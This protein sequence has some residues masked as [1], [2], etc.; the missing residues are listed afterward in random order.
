MPPPPPVVDS[1]TARS[2]DGA[3]AS[4]GVK[5]STNKRRNF[6]SLIAL[7]G[8]AVSLANLVGSGDLSLFSVLQRSLCP[9]PLH[10]SDPFRTELSDVCG[11]RKRRRQRWR[12]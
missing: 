5:E 10:P 6:L 12:Q 4:E 7:I 9:S 11:K 2:V 1:L 3:Q 8:V